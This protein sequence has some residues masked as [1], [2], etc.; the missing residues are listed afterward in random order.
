MD[1]QTPVISPSPTK[2]AVEHPVRRFGIQ[3]LTV[4]LVA[5]V[6]ATL[7]TAWTPGEEP[8]SSGLT[9]N[10]GGLPLPSSLRLVDLFLHLTL[11]CSSAWSLAIGRRLWCSVQRL[12]CKK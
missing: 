4:I 10:L 1:M 5:A 11:A 6:L 3:L 2:S 12:V 7:F 9:L 8:S